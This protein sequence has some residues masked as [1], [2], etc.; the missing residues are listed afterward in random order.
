MI[1][2]TLAAAAVACGLLGASTGV[3]FATHG[4]YVERTD[5][6]GEQHCRYIAQGQTSKGPDDPGG[7][8]FHENVH[9]GEPGGE[10]PNGSENGT[11]FN[12]TGEPG[13]PYVYEDDCE[14][15]YERDDRDARRNPSYSD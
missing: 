15:V 8:K 13:D 2:R 6:D 12:K 14:Y 1:K 5:K 7:H 3:A 11:D 4:H 10:Q 9:T